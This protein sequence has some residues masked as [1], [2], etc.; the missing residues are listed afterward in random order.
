MAME[1]EGGR[2]EEVDVWRNFSKRRKKNLRNSP[3]KKE[4]SVTKSE[5]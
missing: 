1:G 5:N 2:Y 4:F 3:K